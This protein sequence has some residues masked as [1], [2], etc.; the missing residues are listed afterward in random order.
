MVSS[1]YFG[2]PILHA[3]CNRLIS[4]N[5]IEALSAEKLN[6]AGYALGACISFQSTT[7]LIY[8]KNPAA[9][10]TKFIVIVEMLEQCFKVGLSEGDVG[11]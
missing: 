4:P 9:D 8:L 1:C 2:Y 3:A 7:S 10:N 11:V 5:L 6:S